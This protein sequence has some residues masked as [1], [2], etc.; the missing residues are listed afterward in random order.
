MYTNKSKILEKYK[1]SEESFNKVKN[2]KE[3]M[4]KKRTYDSYKSH[5]YLLLYNLTSL[6]FSSSTPTPF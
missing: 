2:G 4:L 3:I 5:L 1:N 6:T